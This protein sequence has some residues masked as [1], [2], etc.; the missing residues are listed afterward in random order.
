MRAIASSVVSVLIK[1]TVWRYELPGSLFIYDALTIR[2][3]ASPT[4]TRSPRS[5]Y[6]TY[7]II[8][9]YTHVIIIHII[10]NIYILYA[11]GFPAG[12]RGRLS[13]VCELVY[14]IL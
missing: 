9:I 5:L 13:A 2:R 6:Y 11:I 3:Y 1:R 12:F 4:R 7:Y 8:S 10:H 14:T